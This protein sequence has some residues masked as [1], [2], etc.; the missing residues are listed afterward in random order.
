MSIDK[1]TEFYEDGVLVRREIQYVTRARGGFYTP[2][3]KPWVSPYRTDIQPCV[4]Y[5]VP[6]V[7]GTV[8]KNGTTT[9]AT[10]D[11]TQA[12][13]D[14][15]DNEILEV[16]EYRPDGTTEQIYPGRYA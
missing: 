16:W 12:L 5:R 6:R 8:I 11:S 3:P 10:T 14:E 4:T 7:D 15:I 2:P 13:L 1:I 9:T